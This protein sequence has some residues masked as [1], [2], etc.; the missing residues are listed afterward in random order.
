EG[1]HGVA[2]LEH[3]LG[4]A[5]KVLDGNGRARGPATLAVLRRLNVLDAE[6]L[7]ELT[8]FAHPVVY[9]RAGRAVGEIRAALDG[10]ESRGTSE[11]VH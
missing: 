1:V 9:N 3:R 11:E 2:A 4:W 6:K 10:N 5:C 8:R 7:R